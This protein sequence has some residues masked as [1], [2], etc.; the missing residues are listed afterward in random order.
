M[1]DPVWRKDVLR[2]TIRTVTAVPIRDRGC[3]RIAA[4]CCLAV[5]L[6]T[7]VPECE[8]LGAETEPDRFALGVRDTEPLAP[9]EEQ[10]TFTVPKGFRV[11]LVASEPQ[12]AKPMNLAFD[13]RGRLWVTSSEEYPFAT[14][15]GVA[16]RDTVRILEDTDGDGRAD[17][18][19]TFADGLNIPI[20]LY[21][22]RDGCICFSIPNI[23]FLRDTD[24]D[25]RCDVREVLYG[26]FD[27]SRDTHGMCNAFRRGDDGWIYAC[28]GFNNQSQVKGRDGNVV[29]MH[30]GNT[31]RFRPDGSRIEHFTIGQ[32]NPF[33][34]AIDRFGD[35]L[36]ADCHTKPVTL[37]MKGGHYESFG[38]PHDGLGF[39]PNVMDHLHGS[40]A[41][42]GISLGEHTQ[43]PPE[44]QQSSFGGNVM[45]SRINRNELQHAGSTVRAV[46]QPDLLSSTDPWFRPVDLVAGPDGALYV[47]DF[48]NRIIGHYEVDLMHPGRDRF[49]GRIWKVSSEPGL[50]SADHNISKASAETLISQLITAFP[51]KA[52]LIADQLTD[53][54]GMLAIVPLQNAMDHESPVLRRRALRILERLDGLNESIIRNATR[55]FD[56]L[57]RVHAFRVLARGHETG[58]ENS[59]LGGISNGLRTELLRGVL[60][61]SSAM[62]L[63]AGIAAMT[64]HPEESFVVPLMQLFHQTSKEDV[65]LR[66][67]TR[68]A[69]QS[70][71][72]NPE[73]F[74]IAAAEAERHLSNE[75]DR[76]TVNGKT[77]RNAD[78]L[79]I[80]GIC[81]SL[82]TPASGEFIAR[83]VSELGDAKPN[84]LPEYLRFASAHVTPETAESIAK[85][86]RERFAQD[87]ALQLQLLESLRAGFSQRSL[88]PPTAVL[89]WAEDMTAQ[90]LEMKSPTDIEA[91][92]TPAAIP[93]TYHKHSESPNPTNCWVPSRAR[94][95]ADGEERSL[96]FSSIELGEQRTGIYRSGPF[97]LSESFSFYLAGHDGV[98]D[99]DSQGK[100]LVRLR[101][102]ETDEVLLQAAPPRNDVAALVNWSTQ[103]W[104]GRNAVIELVDGDAGAAFAWIAAGRF[105]DSRLNP[106]ETGTRRVQAAALIGSYQL[107]VFEP[108]VRW[109]LV[110]S[111]TKSSAQQAAA[112]AIVKLHPDSRLAA[113]VHVIGIAGVPDTVVQ[114]AVNVIES[115]NADAAGTILGDAA[116][117]ATMA[118]QQK[119]A[120]ILASEIDGGRMLLQLAESGRLAA[121]LLVRPSVRQ[122]LDAVSDDAMKAQ[123]SALTAALPAEDVAIERLIRERRKNFSSAMGNAATGRELFRKHC[124]VC[125]QVG[126]EGK[127]VGP[128]L[129][130]IGGRGVDRIIEDVLAPNRNVD[131]AF[132]TTTVVTKSGQAFSGLLRELEGESMSIIDGQGRETLLKNSEIDERVPSSLSPMP[133]NVSEILNEEQF[134]HLL[135]WLAS[136]RQ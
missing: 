11:E 17:V 132:R 117:S 77:P 79:L 113:L 115:G 134:Y 52:R 103:K 47:A 57:V 16:A 64:A 110:N 38:R 78:V 24:G 129:D 69:L 46:E 62:V 75:S 70:H 2:L 95:S 89:R 8:L 99:K 32:V 116:Q 122:S 7:P 43:F 66:H 21:P 3:A 15:E 86:V 13:S 133:A 10:K 55:D 76:T 56:E 51:Q 34:M 50:K 96:L 84:Q 109:L 36:T 118:D 111:V 112:A 102:A 106:D 30:S 48:Y 131:V 67:A 92:K 5:S 6:M 22:Y 39:V 54:I 35:L 65:H 74:P 101:D 20:G 82:R 73:M 125:H 91:L 37:L 9:D 12:I 87:T 27:T 100:N 97:V 68:M 25:D 28:H 90:L 71:L 59:G 85:T 40:T 127:K 121:G 41:I 120:E 135:T 98:P 58:S 61:D 33:G 123:K 136:L 19:K 23:L 26:P 72:K 128:N 130:G 14:K 29:T 45:T 81:L 126:G 83:W 94:R 88:Q 107:T 53:R 114:S 63:R 80:A 93:W 60:N 42:G 108:A 104:Q 44:F 1:P 105:S 4:F 119:I 124:T 18:V 49:R 31:F